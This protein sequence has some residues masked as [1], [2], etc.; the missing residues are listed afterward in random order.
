M[1]NVHREII[2]MTPR[3]NF[4]QAAHFLMKIQY[5]S[6]MSGFNIFLP[7]GARFTNIY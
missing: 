3:K 4:L 5:G 7:R 1:T 2:V 6:D